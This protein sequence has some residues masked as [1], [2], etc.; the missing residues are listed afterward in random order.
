MS[1]KIARTITHPSNRAKA[2]DVRE[3]KTVFKAVLDNPH[4]IHWCVPVAGLERPLIM[5]Q[6]PS[7]PL[8][9]QNAILAKILQLLDGTSEYQLQRFA[10]G[11]KR[12][13]GKEKTS[14]TKKQKVELDESQSSASERRDED[15]PPVLSGLPQVDM[16]VELEPPA[17]F[18]HLVY[19]INE[20]TKRLENQTQAVRRSVVARLPEQPAK[21]PLPTLGSIFVCRSDM[22]LSL[23]LD[24]LPHLIAAYNSSRPPS[25]VTLVPLPK[26]AELSLAQALG[27]RRVSV[28]GI[29][30]GPFQT[31]CGRLL[32][33]KCF[34]HR[35]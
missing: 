18:R 31:Y 11:R 35:H 1:D 2:K 22:N 15:G 8:N 17:L 21:D 12:K 28:F 32:N 9:L 20:V 26:G 4:R 33:W 30:V 13:C 34:H 19:G 10:A 24:H 7:V 27:V 6:R 14:Q 5:K 25:F 23:P 3:T 16:V 29:E